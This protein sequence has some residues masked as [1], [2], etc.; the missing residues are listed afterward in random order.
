[1]NMLAERMR[2]A[3]VEQKEKER[4][5]RQESILRKN[6]YKSKG[7]RYTIDDFYLLKI[8]G[9]GGFGKVFLAKDKRS[10]QFV[11]IKSVQKPI[12]VSYEDYEITLTERSVLSLGSECIFLTNLVCS[13]QT[14]ER[15]FY[16]MEYLSGGDL[17]FHLYKVAFIRFYFYLLQLQIF[18]RRTENLL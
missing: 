4:R 3:K 10:K 16:V 5:K 2:D 18:N 6:K 13:F 12:I 7:R 8:L 14:Q 9:S 15:L 17:L 1:M 11:A